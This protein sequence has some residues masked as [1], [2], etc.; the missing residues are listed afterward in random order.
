MRTSDEFGPGVL[1]MPSGNTYL[2]G[3]A[4]CYRIK[5]GCTDISCT[6]LLTDPDRCYGWHCT[7]CD[8]ACG[9]QGHTCKPDK[10]TN[11]NS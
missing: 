2:V 1:K 11:A 5:E 8:E 7:R 4:V 9:P 10:N 3:E 6:R